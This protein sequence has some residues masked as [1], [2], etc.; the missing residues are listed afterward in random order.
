MPY[1][2]FIS[3]IKLIYTSHSNIHGASGNGT[4]RNYL[5]KTFEHPDGILKTCYKTD[6]LGEKHLQIRKMSVHL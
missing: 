2:K 5:L 3:K 6:Y 1:K 4:E